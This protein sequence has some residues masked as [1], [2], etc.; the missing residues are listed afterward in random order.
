LERKALELLREGQGGY[1]NLRDAWGKG[2]S[3]IRGISW[4]VLE[5]DG[6]RDMPELVQQGKR[7]VYAIRGGRVWRFLQDCAS[8][9]VGEAGETMVGAGIGAAEY[10]RK[11]KSY[12]S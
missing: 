1:K 3:C 9:G 10:Q 5:L 12:Y 2:P 6:C 8:T 7:S 4:R 11:K